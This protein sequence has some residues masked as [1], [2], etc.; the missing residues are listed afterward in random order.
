MQNEAIT[1]ESSP[2]SVEIKH[3]YRWLSLIC[4]FQLLFWTMGPWLARNTLHSDTLEGIAW[5]NLWQWGYDKHPPLAAWIAAFFSNLSD[6]SDWP[7]YLLAQIC[8]VIAFIAIWKLAREYLTGAGALLAVFLLQ[9]I[10]FYSNRVERVTPDTLQHPVWA[11]LALTFYFAV[12]RQS[13]SYWLITGVMAGLAILTKYQ[14]I[15]LFAP[16]LIV[17]LITSEGRKAL[18]SVGPWLGGIVALT[19]AAP[20]LYWLWENNFAAV[21]YLE[22]NYVE[23]A[24]YGTGTDWDHL[25]FPFSFI[26]NSLGNI[27]VLFLLMIP[28]F[29]APKLPI[30]YPSFKKVFLIAIATGPFAFTLVFGLVT[31]EKLVPRWA[32]PYFAWLPLL[33]LVWLRP[34]IDYQR[35]KKIVLWCL[36]T[37]LIFVSL[38]CSYLLFK[39]LFDDDYWDSVEFMPLRAQMLKAEEL[40]SHHYNQPMHY[41]GGLHYH[42]AELIA[43]SHNRKTTPFFGLNPAESLWMKEEDFRKKGG[44]IVM[45]DG[46]RNSEQ[47]RQRLEKNYPQAEFLGRFEFEPVTKIKINDKPKLVVEYYLIRPQSIQK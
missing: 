7:V 22:D 12:T 39:P 14:A 41:L 40:W 46:K 33:I 47:V 5:G 38:R 3:P 27:F 44:I 17:L 18:S 42:V 1:A 45:V 9:G 11:L 13:I 28:L 32:T 16:L 31:G 23:S 43:Y 34:L 19:I 29:R 21:S 15:V 2:T 24:R 8:V 10:L 35:F 36:L 37:G 20:H 30:V 6:T 25:T 26:K 4:L